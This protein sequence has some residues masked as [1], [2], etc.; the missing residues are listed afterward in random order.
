MYL[1]VLVSTQLLGVYSHYV[2]KKLLIHVGSSTTQP[3][4][5]SF[6]SLKACYSFRCLYSYYVYSYSCTQPLVVCKA[7]VLYLLLVD[8]STAT[9]SSFTLVPDLPKLQLLASTDTCFYSC[10]FTLVLV[11]LRLHAA[12]SLR[13]RP[14]TR[15]YSPSRDLVELRT[16]RS[17]VHIIS[18]T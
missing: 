12:L 13:S 11:H 2:Y 4:R 3:T 16:P 10:S 18:Y 17:R 5:S 7:T 8:V 14:A 15:F 1:Q 6:A 9:H